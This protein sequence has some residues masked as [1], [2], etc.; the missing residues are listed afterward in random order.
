MTEL[1]TTELVGLLTSAINQRDQKLVN[2]YAREL[3]VRLYFPGSQN[4]FKELLEGFGYREIEEDD[5]QIS[6][7]EYMRGRKKDDRES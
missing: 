1:T 6:I 7:D 4:A 3:A 5:R 2:I